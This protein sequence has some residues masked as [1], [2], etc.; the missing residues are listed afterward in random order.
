LLVLGWCSDLFYA[1]IAG[2]GGSMLRQNLRFLRV[3]RYFAGSVY[4]GLG[5]TAA[6]TGGNRK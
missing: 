1:L 3:Q 6:L 5:L 4:I 2:T